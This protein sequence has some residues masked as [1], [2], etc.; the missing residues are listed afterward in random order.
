MFFEVLLH[1]WR[2]GPPNSPIAI[3]TKIGWIIA[4]IT[5]TEN[6]KVVSCHTIAMS[7]DILKRFWEVEDLPIKQTQFTG[8]RKNAW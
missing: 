5:N 8:Q 7:D 6:T 3:E 2:V 4:G 1:G